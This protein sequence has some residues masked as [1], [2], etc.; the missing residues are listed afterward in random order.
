MITWFVAAALAA[1]DPFASCEDQREYYEGQQRPHPLQRPTLWWLERDVPCPVGTTIVGEQPPAGRFV[2]CQ[3]KRGRRY[4]L[5]T[6]F[7]FD[8]K[9]SLETRWDRGLEVGPRLEWDPVTYTLSKQ[10]ELKDGRLDGESLSWLPDGG[11]LV[12]S[13][14]RGVKEGPTYRL[15]ERGR[16]MMLEG[17]RLDMRHGR[18][19]SW[20]E[21]SLFVDQVYRWGEPTMLTATRGAAP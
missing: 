16:L 19:C 13:Y 12:T 15:D 11:V 1:P 3:D 2:G 21:G 9:V 8:G 5:R 18:A 20:H 7:A 14:R 4:G 6:E 10:S 17:W